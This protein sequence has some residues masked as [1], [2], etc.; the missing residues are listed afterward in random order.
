MND[1]FD[2]LINEWDE[3]A[4]PPSSQPPPPRATPEAPPGIVPQAAVSVREALPPATANLDLSMTMI[5]DIVVAGVFLLARGDEG[6]TAGEAVRE[7]MTFWNG[8][9]SRLFIIHNL[10][11]RL[12]DLRKIFHDSADAPRYIL[13][14]KEHTQ[15]GSC[16]RYYLSP[17]G[18]DKMTWWL[19]QGRSGKPQLG[20]LA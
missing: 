2:D 11:S 3:G 15:K 10:R 13:Y 20:I 1:D 16:K 18:R 8:E 9:V 19:T 5:E 17:E 7:G 12:S 6:L 4:S 14:R